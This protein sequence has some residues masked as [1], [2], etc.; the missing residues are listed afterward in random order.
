MPNIERRDQS[1]ATPATPEAKTGPLMAERSSVRSGGGHGGWLYG[2]GVAGG[3]T[4][5]SKGNCG[6]GGKCGAGGNCGAGSNGSAGG[7][8]GD[9]TENDGTGGNGGSAVAR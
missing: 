8:G 9:I 6:A 7:A 5:G 2:N 3:E 1:L 4:S